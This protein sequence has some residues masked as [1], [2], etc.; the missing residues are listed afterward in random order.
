M[1]R[2]HTDN[3]RRPGNGAARGLGGMR[4]TLLG[5]VLAVLAL[6]GCSVA[7]ATAA[8][9]GSLPDGVTVFDNRYA[10]ITRLDVELLEALRRAASSAEES[11]VEIEVNSGW[12]SPAHQERLLA[13]AVA[14]YG[15]AAAA[16]RWVATARTS[17]HV[18]GQAVDVAGAD[19]VAWLSRRGAAYG[20]CRIYRNEPWH[21][22]LRPTAPTAGCP[23]M[24][25][26]PAHDPR[27]QR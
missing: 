15:S 20:L 16:A 14:E 8:D 18:A 4:I 17:A 23:A 24:Y 21:F 1:Y 3:G 7:P 5:A 2:G 27:M 19:A 9:D 6:A 22:E 25:A 11:G 26:D 12:R 10:G 13:E